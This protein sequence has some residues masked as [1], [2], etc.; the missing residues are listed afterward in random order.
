MIN[1]NLDHLPIAIK[2]VPIPEVDSIR[3][4]SLGE[5]LL[6]R[7]IVVLEHRMLAEAVEAVEM[8]IGEIAVN[9]VYEPFK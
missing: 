3:T 5:A 2:K 6:F 9:E 8:R 7:D 4:M 1:S